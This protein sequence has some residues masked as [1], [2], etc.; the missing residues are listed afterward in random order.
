[1]ERTKLT[2]AHCKGERFIG[3]GVPCADCKGSGFR[4]GHIAAIGYDD[5]TS[6][7]EV[8][9]RVNKSGV[10]PVWQYSP[11]DRDAFDAMMDPEQSAGKIFAGRVKGALGV[12]ETRMADVEHVTA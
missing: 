8:E 1:M 12:H 9:Y 3:N 2:C 7:L 10:S 11:V 6:T 5:A 4:S